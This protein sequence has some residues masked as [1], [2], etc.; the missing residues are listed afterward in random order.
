MTDD[1]ALER[2]A[3]TQDPDAFRCLVLRYQRMVYAASHRCLNNHADAEDATQETFLRLAKNAGR[4]HGRVGAWLHRCA[5]HVAIDR[6]RSDTARRRREDASARSEAERAPDSAEE[7]RELDRAVD[8]AI[9]ELNPADRE[10]LVG[11]YLQGRTQVELAKEVG[12]SQAGMSRRRDRALG[13]VRRQLKRRGIVAAAGAVVSSLEGYTAQSQLTTPLTESLLRIGVSG[14]GAQPL[15]T[16]TTTGGLLMASSWT[17][18]KIVAALGV[19]GLLVGGSAAI[20]ATTGEEP[21]A[22]PAPVAAPAVSPAT[23]VALAASRPTSAKVGDFDV[24]FETIA[25][26]SL[27]YSEHPFTE[28]Q[29]PRIGMEWFPRLMGE[30]QNGGYDVA[31]PPVLVFQENPEDP[32]DMALRLSIPVSEADLESPPSEGF[33]AYTTEP[34]YCAR[35]EVSDDPMM[36]GNTANAYYDA[37]EAAGYELGYEFRMVINRVYQVQGKTINDIYLQVEVLKHPE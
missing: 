27:V 11:Y 6:I 12:I 31:G 16:T 23:P 26:Q 14:V 24:T 35:I 18:G 8:Q 2:Y 29:V 13:K 33:H 19:A 37:L 20:M 34:Y 32:Q 5:T 1:Q 7:A 10:A 22:T 17:T 36:F 28:D 25:P 9:A 21:P 3:A 4:V 30:I 15:T